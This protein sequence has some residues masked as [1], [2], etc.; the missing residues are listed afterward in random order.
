MTL[1]AVCGGMAIRG[2][3]IH[4][5]L[6]RLHADDEGG[7]LMPRWR[8]LGRLQ[9]R[10]YTWSWSNVKRIDV[11]RGPFGGVHGVRIV[12]STRPEQTAHAGL[13]GRWLVT[14]NRFVI[15]LDPTLTEELLALVPSTIPRAN[16]RGLF[17][18]G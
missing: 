17:V 5:P 14:T 8:W 7:Q 11:L 2:V 6:V 1:D 16:R 3:G 12:L 9:F 18:W 13:L 15:G 4:G 10:D